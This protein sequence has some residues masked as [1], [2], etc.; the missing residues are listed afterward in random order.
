MT[1]TDMQ[2]QAEQQWFARLKGLLDSLPVGAY[3]TDEH[4]DTLT[5]GID[6]LRFERGSSVKITATKER[7]VTIEAQEGCS[8]AH[9]KARG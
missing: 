1:L 8:P 5:R 4:A 6:A 9:E 3:L 7:T 2:R